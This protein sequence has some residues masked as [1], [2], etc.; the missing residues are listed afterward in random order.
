ML[1][2][3]EVQRQHSQIII[4]VRRIVNFFI[5]IRMPYKVRVKEEEKVNK[6]SFIYFNSIYGKRQLDYN[7][8]VTDP[9]IFFS[10]PGPTLYL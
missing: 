3:I 8:I 7:S 10:G 2:F 6:S 4:P 5:K 9:Y 1:T